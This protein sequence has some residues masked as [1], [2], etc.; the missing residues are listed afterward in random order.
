MQ[1]IAL[2]AP[3]ALGV[4]GDLGTGNGQVDAYAKRRAIV[5]M[6][7]E[8]FDDY[9]TANDSVEDRVELRALFFD[10]LA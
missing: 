2:G 3:V 8:L 10:E 1:R 9:V 5:K 6:P 4:D 7:L